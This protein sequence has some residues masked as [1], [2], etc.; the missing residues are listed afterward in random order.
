MGWPAVKGVHAS[1]LTLPWSL[2]SAMAHGFDHPTTSI[3]G[4]KH[5]L[6]GQNRNL[7]PSTFAKPNCLLVKLQLFSTS[8]EALLDEALGPVEIHSFVSRTLKSFR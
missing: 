1:Y 4:S 6:D 7:F 8:N 2:V 5:V 3:P